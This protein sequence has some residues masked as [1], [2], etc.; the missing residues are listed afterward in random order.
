MLTVHDHH[1]N[2]DNHDYHGYH[3]HHIYSQLKAQNDRSQRVVV[4]VGNRRPLCRPETVDSVP[5]HW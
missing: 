1:D 3:G 5:K 4:R 2:H